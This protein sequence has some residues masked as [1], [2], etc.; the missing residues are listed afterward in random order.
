LC[1]SCLTKGKVEQAHAVDHVFPWRQF[2]E[3][4]F[5]FNLFQSL[6]RGHHSLKTAREQRGEYLCYIDGEKTLT[7]ADW[8]SAVG[9]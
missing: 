6:C 8:P 7:E 1:Q 4:A 2:G 9:G 3:R 5:R